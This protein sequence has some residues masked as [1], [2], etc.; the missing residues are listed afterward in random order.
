MSGQRTRS[1]AP[2]RQ[3]DGSGATLALRSPDIPAFAYGDARALENRRKHP[4]LSEEGALLADPCRAT[5]L[6]A[7]SS[8]AVA[9]GETGGG[10]ARR[11]EPAPARRALGMA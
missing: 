9:R 8:A 4:P 2:F 10:S 11:A 3:F 5:H 7:I 6:P 1:L